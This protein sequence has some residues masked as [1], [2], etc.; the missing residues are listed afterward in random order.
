M[1][2]VVERAVEGIRIGRRSGAQL[3][4]V[5]DE[6]FDELIVDGLVNDHASGRGAI[7]AAVEERCLGDAGGGLLD[8]DVAEDDRRRFAAQFEVRALELLCCGHGDSD[9][10]PHRTGDRDE[11]EGRVLHQRRSGSAVAEHDVEHAVRQDALRELRQD[12]RAARCGVAGLEDDRVAGREGGPDLPQRHHERVVPWS[13]LTDDADRLTT[14]VGGET[15]HVLSG[16][17][18]SR[19]RAAPAKNRI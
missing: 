7:L 4:G 8:V 15:L 6:G 16:R 19:S 5:P 9:A 3:L 18:A 11:T 12:Q 13:D 10:R 17:L 14:D 2:D 1:I